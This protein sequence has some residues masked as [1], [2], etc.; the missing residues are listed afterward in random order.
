MKYKSTQGAE[1]E[2]CPTSCRK[3]ATHCRS[4]L[5]VPPALELPLRGRNLKVILFGPLLNLHEAEGYAVLD[6]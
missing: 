6:L 3:A 5:L 2:G 1:Y 4:A